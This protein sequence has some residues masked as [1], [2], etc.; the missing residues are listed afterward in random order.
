MYSL[1]Q[2]LESVQLSWRMA[3]RTIL[4]SAGALI[5]TAAFSPARGTFAQDA[6]V[7]HVCVSPGHKSRSGFMLAHEQFTVPHLVELGA[8]IEALTT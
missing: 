3:R 8:T 6:D 1:R 5:G 2:R 7:G 4:Q